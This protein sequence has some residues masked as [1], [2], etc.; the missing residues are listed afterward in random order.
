MWQLLRLEGAFFLGQGVPLSSGMLPFALV[1]ILH[2]IQQAQS[3]GLGHV[4]SFSL[5]ILTSD[6]MSSHSNSSGLQH[7][8]LLQSQ[9]LR[10]D[11]CFWNS[12]SPSSKAFLKS[13]LPQNSDLWC[14]PLSV[15]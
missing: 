8:S 13:Y 10:R 4:S 14:L 15:V 6:F 12:P 9:G 3:W 2:R 1:G 5:P 7:I 11:Y